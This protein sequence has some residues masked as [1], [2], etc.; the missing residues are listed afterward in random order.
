M[1]DDVVTGNCDGAVVGVTDGLLDGT[2][3]LGRLGD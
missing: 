3:V 1:G 2:V